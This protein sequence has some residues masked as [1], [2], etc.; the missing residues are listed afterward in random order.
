MADFCKQCSE[1]L[2]GEDFK[3]LAKLGDPKKME[4]GFYPVVLCEGCGPIQVD[5]FGKC[6]SP[7]CLK[8]HGKQ[9]DGII[10]NGIIPENI[11]E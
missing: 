7:D 3:D 2:F 5:Y 4:Q 11:K 1:E 10:S 6:I 9:M 8:K